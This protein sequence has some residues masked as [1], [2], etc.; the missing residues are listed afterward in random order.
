[1][2]LAFDGPQLERQR[3]P[4]GMGG[5]NHPGAGQFGGVREAVEIEAHPVGNEQEQPSHAGRELAGGGRE[6]A[7]IGDR[8]GGRSDEGGPFLVKTP[9]QRRET[10]LGEDL[11]H[12]CGAQCHPLPLEGLADLVDRIIALTQRHDLF[13]GGALPWPLL[14]AGS[15]RCE[16]IRQVAVAEAV[17]EHPES[18]GGIAKRASDL[19]RWPAFEEIGPERLILTLARGGGLP[20]EAPAFC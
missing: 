20:E 2:A 16:E 17:A 8:L 12:R 6:T 15:G 13:A 7:H 19:G 4:Q 18:T 11:A 3:G 9:G 1:M 14:G 10:F 5:G